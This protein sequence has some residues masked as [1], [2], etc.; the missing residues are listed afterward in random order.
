MNFSTCNDPLTLALFWLGPEIIVPQCD[1]F[2]RGTVTAT[3]FEPLGYLKTF[4]LTNLLEAPFYFW[5]LREHSV[6]V[7]G[8][9]LFSANLLTHPIVYFLLPYGFSLLGASYGTFLAVG[10][11]FALLSEIALLRVVW[12]TSLSRTTLLIFLG[13][14]FSWWVGVLF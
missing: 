5:L 3:I 10:E 9:A 7:R 13:N 14:L 11:G 1:W 12:K 4:A 8:T 6:R 2:L